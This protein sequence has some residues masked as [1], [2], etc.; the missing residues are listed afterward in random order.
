M[1]SAGLTLF[2]GSRVRVPRPLYG[3]GSPY[4]DYGQGFYCTRE[5]DLACE[6]ACPT[7]QDGYL[8]EYRLALTGLEVLDLCD[9]SY[10]LLNWLAVLVENRRFD[11][12]T[13]LMREARAYLMR[14]YPVDLD[15]FDVVTGYRA[16]DSYFSFARAFLDGRISLRQLGLAMNIGELGV[17]WFLRS[18]RAFERVSFVGSS[19]VEGALW[20]PRRAERDVAARLAYRSLAEEPMRLD[21]VF[22]IDLIRGEG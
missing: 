12:T 18:P 7:A 8:N 9:P 4:N 2:H 14:H 5:R 3:V 16:D 1:A 13:P 10:G 11:I 6:W 17:Q 19:T 20:G 21:D 15:A 22:V